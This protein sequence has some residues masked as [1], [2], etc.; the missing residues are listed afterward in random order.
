MADKVSDGTNL[1]SNTA[2]LTW[3]TEDTEPDPDENYALHLDVYHTIPK[4]EYIVD[5]YGDTEE[6]P[7]QLIVTNVGDMPLV[8]NSYTVSLNGASY[9]VAVPSQYLKPTDSYSFTLSGTILNETQ[10]KPGSGTATTLGIVTM[11]FTAHA[12]HPEWTD[13]GVCDSNTVSLDHTLVEPGPWTPD[14]ADLTI[15]KAE[16]SY[17]VNP[18]GYMLDDTITYTITVTNTGALDIP[19]VEIHDDLFDDG[20]G[21]NV[22]AVIT[23]LAPA[24]SRTVNFAYVVTQGDVDAKWVINNATAEWVEPI[25]GAP[26]TTPAIPVKSPTTDE[27]L[28]GGLVIV[29]SVIGGPDNGSYYTPGEKITFHVAV[30]NTMD[31]TITDIW[32]YDA[33]NAPVY[34]GILPAHDTFEWSY[35]YEAT[36][37]DAKILGYVSNIAYGWGFYDSTIING[38][39]NEVTVPVHFNP[40]KVP[41]LQLSKEEVSK[42]A[43]GSY[44]VEGEIIDY[45]IS[46]KNVGETVIYDVCLFDSLDSPPFE[47]A[48]FGVLY[49]DEQ[50]SALYDHTVTKADVDNGYVENWALADYSVYEDDSSVTWYSAIAGPVYSPTCKNPVIKKKTPGTG[51]ADSCKLTLA[52]VGSYTLAQEQHYCATHREVLDKV[53]ELTGAAVTDA[54]KAEAWQTGVTLWREALEAEYDE[55]MKACDG[56]ARLAVMEEKTAFD[57]Y[58]GGLNT[59]LQALYPNDA[60]LVSRLLCTAIEKQCTELCYLGS[61]AGAARPDSMYSGSYEAIEGDTAAGKC[62]LSMNKA[63][64]GDVMFTVKLCEEHG[65]MLAT[66]AYLMQGT[67]NR[68]AAEDTFRRIRRVWQGGLDQA[69]NVKYRAAEGDARTGVGAYRMAFDQLVEKH[70]DMLAQFYPAN[71]EIV[72]EVIGNMVR[73]QLLILCGIW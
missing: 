14:L 19:V 59:M 65:K 11:S 35:D 72:A 53:S 38:T 8:F 7:F 15:A 56:A 54:E 23:N 40:P 52:G 2:A 69:T 45:V 33:F 20:G 70:G 30:T 47:Y 18:K 13:I 58:L 26:V 48:H 61:N 55:L 34:I 4:S 12:V 50:Q 28:P 62:A 41:M 31:V 25:T 9:T 17:H 68:T 37:M 16:T 64:S 44:Y 27:P 60:A 71:P 46:A 39:S 24:E 29:K 57:K 36:E 42:P 51:K 43:N 32:I 6:I 73:D 3:L 63:H 66:S 67:A 22:L 21:G 10:V 1:V 5:E 49:P